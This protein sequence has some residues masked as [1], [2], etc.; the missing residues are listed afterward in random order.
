MDILPPDPKQNQIP[1]RNN[2]RMKENDSGR[3]KSLLQDF[4]KRPVLGYYDPWEESD[5]AMR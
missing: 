3:V 5:E 2:S 4:V 1:L